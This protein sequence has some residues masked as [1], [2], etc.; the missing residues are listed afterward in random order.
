LVWII[1]KMSLE[2]RHRK[3]M[4]EKKNKIRSR[5]LDVSVGGSELC[6]PRTL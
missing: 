3:K 5:M 2:R 6:Y 1:I 4:N